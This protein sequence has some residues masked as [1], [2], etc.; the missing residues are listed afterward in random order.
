MLFRR[1]EKLGLRAKMRAMF[2]PKRSFARSLRYLQKRVLRLQATP[3]AIAAGFAAGVFASFTPL[4]GFHFLLSFAV[5]YVIAG[6]MAAAALGCIIGNPLTFPAIWAGTYEVGRYILKAEAIDGTAPVGL[7]HALT[8]GDFLAMWE[9]YLKP[10][11]VG[12][13]PL[14]LF[15]GA[16]SYAL[17]YFAAKSFQERRARNLM[18]R[19]DL[20]RQAL[21]DVGARGSAG[22]P[23]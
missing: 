17:I 23:S 20:R 10:M 22:E 2:W 4:I 7:G 11:L 21:S 6:N 5:A 9:P 15:F 19:A 12:S 18:L 14:G 8:H 13:L 3:H 16:I 1:R